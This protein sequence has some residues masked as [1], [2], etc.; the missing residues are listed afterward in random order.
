MN[1]PKKPTPLTGSAPALR[2]GAGVSAPRGDSGVLPAGRAES[3]FSAMLQHAGLWDLVQLRCESRVRCVVCVTSG[4]QVGFL[5][6]AEGQ[7][8]HAV[9]GGIQ[10]ERAVLDIPC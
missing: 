10:G 2:G 5:Y 3:G 4:R 8:V 9:T 1:E 7:I 6:F